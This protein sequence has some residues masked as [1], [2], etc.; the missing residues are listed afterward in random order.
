MACKLLVLGRNE[1]GTKDIIK[2]KKTGLLYNNF[3]ELKYYFN[4]IYKNK[5][6]YNHIIE[7]AHNFI[8]PFS[9]D[10]YFFFLVNNYKKCN[11]PNKTKN[12]YVYLYTIIFKIIKIFIK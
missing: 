5:N 3:E 11:I 10:N 6:K 1:N 2:H 9:A 7:N 4:D 8:L 12:I